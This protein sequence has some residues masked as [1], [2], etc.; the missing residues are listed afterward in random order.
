[1]LSVQGTLREKRK[2]T[3]DRNI[4]TVAIQG[5]FTNPCARHSGKRGKESSGNSDQALY[6]TGDAEWNQS[7]RLVV[8]AIERIDSGKI[9]ASQEPP[10]EIQQVRLGLRQVQSPQPGGEG[11]L[12]HGPRQASQDVCWLRSTRG[13]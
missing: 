5:R 13:S 11:V 3:I 10:T 12:R 8:S 1:M 4:H 6:P 2:K 9:K 7:I